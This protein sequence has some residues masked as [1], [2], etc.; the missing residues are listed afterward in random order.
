MKP[1]DDQWEAYLKATPDQLRK[2]REGLRAQQRHDR[3]ALLRIGALVGGTIGL[4]VTWYW[5]GLPEEPYFALILLG[6][7]SIVA[8]E[9][10]ALS[11]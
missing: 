7:F 6:F 11:R 2:A 1:G 10:I 3:P 9:H 8:L 4:G 5:H